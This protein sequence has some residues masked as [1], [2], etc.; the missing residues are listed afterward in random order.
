[1]ALK[2]RE[3]CIEVGSD[4]NTLLLRVCGRG[5]F[6]N[7][8]AIQKYISKMVE[9]G[10]S[11]VVVDS[12]ECSYM[13]SSFLGTLTGIAIRLRKLFKKKLEVANIDPKVKETVCTIGLNHIFNLSERD[14]LGKI[15]VTQLVIATAGKK[16]LAEQMLHA[17]NLLM[18]LSSENKERFQHVKE[19]LE[20][21]L[22]AE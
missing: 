16:E 7:C 1:M 20:Q 4:G 18:E 8:Q 9:E 6:S 14:D 21:E 2:A 15:P 22:A 5:T 13:D 17:H 11:D 19:L 3:G 10:F 12:S